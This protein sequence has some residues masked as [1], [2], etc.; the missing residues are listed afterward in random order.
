MILLFLVLCPSSAG[1]AA[2]SREGPEI[3]ELPGAVIGNEEVRPDPEALWRCQKL[4]GY[5]T[6]VQSFVIEAAEQGA[7]NRPD[8][9]LFTVLRA[10]KGKN[11][12]AAWWFNPIVRGEPRYDWNDFLALFNHVDGLLSR[13][14]WLEGWK[15]A[16]E[17]R[18]LELHAFG[19]EPE[20]EA[21]EI[22]ADVLPI[23]REAKLSGRP[24]YQILARIKNES[25]VELFLNDRDPRM[26]VS[27]SMDLPVHPAHWLDGLDVEFHPGCRKGEASARYAVIEPDGTW[28]MR[29]YGKCRP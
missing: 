2:P 6:L 21:D 17:G 11:L 1:A 3:K 25:W 26:I 27:Y 23:W 15:K 10:E 19:L 29:E 22:R 16:T 24:K 4:R 14:S 13:H 20:T 9:S 18:L 12:N 7:V 28:A 5:L 8:D